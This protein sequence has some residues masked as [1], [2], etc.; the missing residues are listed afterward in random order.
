M[1]RCDTAYAIGVGSTNA[2]LDH[3]SSP[4]KYLQKISDSTQMGAIKNLKY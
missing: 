3:K 2:Q 4:E 1:S